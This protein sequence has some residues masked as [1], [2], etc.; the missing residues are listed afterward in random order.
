[1]KTDLRIVVVGGGRT[2][3]QTARTLDDRGHDV[4]VVERDPERAEEISDD[5]V[6]T[7]IQG[8]GTRPSILEQT[9]LDQVDAVAA[10]TSN[11]GTNLAVCLVADRISPSVRTVMRRTESGDGEYED[12]VDETVYPEHAGARM[13]VNALDPSVRTLEDMVGDLDV[14]VIQVTEEAPVAG[15]K[16]SEIA[17]PE[18]SLVV[19][20]AQGDTTAGPDTVLEPGRSYVVATQPDVEKE[21]HRLFRG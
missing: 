10:L 11:S 13:A 17:I 14:L 7:V 15:K 20:G 18:G 9:D 16:L 2:G 12:L 19:S 4:V 3:L 6:A 21:I 5:Y 8:D 1:M